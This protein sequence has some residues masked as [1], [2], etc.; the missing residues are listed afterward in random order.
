[1][2]TIARNPVLLRPLDRIPSGRILGWSMA[3]IF[4]FHFLL[5][6]AAGQHAIAAS[7]L[8][9]AALVI[10]ASSCGFWRARILPWSERPPWLWASSGMVLW[11]VAHALEAFVGHSPS[12]SV[13]TVDA[14]DFV[15]VSAFF[16]LLIAF[17]TTR[18]TQSLRA[19]FA[20]NC[21]QV[22]LALVLSWVLLY[23]MALAP[24][25]AS[26][27]MGRIY[28]ASCV[29]LAV[30]SVL[31]IFCWASVEERQAFRT[32]NIVVWTYLPVEL[33]MDYLS[34][35]HGLRSGTLLDLVWSVP[36][37]LAGWYALTLPLGI[38][39]AVPPQRS[40]ARLLAECLCP[41]L[42]NAGIFALAAAVIPQH[43]L[44]GLAALFSLLLVQGFQ[45]ALVQ[46]N[47][48]TGRALLLDR[49]L[50]L[51]AANAALQQLTLLDPLTGIANRRRF[52][53]EFDAAW[54]HILRRRT[55]LVLI[56]VDVDYFKG[57]NDQHG[58]TY[59]DRCLIEI[60]RVL[61]TQ[62]RR[63]D[64]LVARIGG[65]EYVL[66]LPDTDLSGAAVVAERLHDAIRQLAIVNHASP[67]DR[68]LTVSIGLAVAQPSPALEPT[69]VFNAADKALYAAK[70]QG[71]N[72]TC[73]VL[74]GEPLETLP[75]SVH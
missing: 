44:L 29:L 48:L 40:R 8:A 25:L 71:R 10:V 55:P 2:S 59:G 51:R 34:Q 72:R 65:E 36:F 18:E 12:G 70:D 35:H 56:L 11:A 24:D 6:L 32:V 3:F 68:L 53:A 31:R 73:T 7:R 63:P 21:A 13:L 60:A 54:R 33:G 37:G 43:M 61:E 19:V 28:G 4:A 49:E 66:L 16:P 5:L 47:Y 74:L 58:H 41:L 42:M 38:E 67:F 69:A 1:M 27:I 62:A 30:M 22:A 64:D 15:Y 14:S 26:T 17:S 9:T 50:E 23:R 39:D 45:A 20:L 46:M 57:I 75:Y 52:D